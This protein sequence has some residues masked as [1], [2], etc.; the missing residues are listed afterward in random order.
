MQLSIAAS[1]FLPVDKGLIPTGEL[2][3]VKGTPFDFTNR[4]SHR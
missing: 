2:K 3:D 1:K 4:D